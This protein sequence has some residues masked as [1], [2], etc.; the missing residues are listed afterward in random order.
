MRQ[1][2][3][4]KCLRSLYGNRQTTSSGQNLASIGINSLPP[5][6]YLHAFLSSA[7]IY[8]INFFENF[9]QEYH[10]GPNCLQR[11]SADDTTDIF[12]INFFEKFLLGIPSKCQTDWIQIRRDILSGLIWA[13]TVC[14]GYQQTT[15][16][17][18]SK[19]PFTKIYFR[20]TI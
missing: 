7:D 12:K 13:Q 16:L 3:M 20:N 5:G 15:L 18:F 11:L 19:S 6:K 2:Q 9:L 17:I 1:P 10:L 8:K 4:L 14:K